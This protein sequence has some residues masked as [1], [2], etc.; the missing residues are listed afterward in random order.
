MKS[1]VFLIAG[2]VLSAACTVTANAKNFC[3]VDSEELWMSVNKD[4]SIDVTEI[5]KIT[6]HG[7]WG[8]MSREFLLQG[9]DGIKISELRVDNVLFTQKS[10][11]R[12]GEYDLNTLEPRL[13]GKG[14]LAPRLEMRWR[15][16]SPSDPPYD[17]TGVRITLKYRVTG[18][19]GQY[20]DYDLL[21]WNP[22]RVYRQDFI[23]DIKVRVLFPDAVKAPDVKFS[24]NALNAVKEVAPGQRMVSFMAQSLSPQ[25]DFRFSIK[26]PKGMIEP[27]KS[28]RNLYYYNLKPWTL[29]VIVAITA[30]F[31]FLLNLLKGRDP[32]VSAEQIA[33][34]NLNYI[35]PGMAGLV[36]DESFD[37]RDIAVTVIDLAKRGFL[38]ITQLSNEP[39]DYE[40]RLLRSPLPDTL[41]KF[42]ENM[43]IEMFGTLTRDSRTT[44]GKLQYNFYRRIARIRHAAWVDAAGWFAVSPQHARNSFLLVG[45]GIAAFGVIMAAI[46]IP[47]AIFL[48]IWCVVFGGIPIYRIIHYI[49][50]NGWR[51][52]RGHLV[53]L[54]LILLGVGVAAYSIAGAYPWT[55]W[56]FDVGVA[57]FISGLLTAAAGPAMA[58]R[59][60]EGC[61]LARRIKQLY[62]RLLEH[63]EQEASL[64]PYQQLIWMLVMANGKT[65]IPELPEEEYKDFF[66][67]L[68]PGGG[69]A[70]RQM[71]LT[72]I[73]S[74]S[75]VSNN[76]V[77]QNGGG[78]VSSCAYSQH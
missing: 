72:L 12:K 44:T 17:Y 60:T 38:K 20:Q 50:D 28:F 46:K 77:A 31:L 62:H 58:R 47:I 69:N 7:K 39:P 4:S 24:C 48:S 29:P 56:V 43:L 6:L 40:I 1:W 27:Y 23:R 53:Y 5:R 33:A 21:S 10:P 61:I 22:L 52:L 54:P 45:L 32:K 34:I 35:R 64:S 13:H 26:L 73:D 14:S 66:Q 16:N 59:N 57:V 55:G 49:K 19:I 15:A 18:A 67:P 8:M 37:H 74:V 71:S 36:I 2:L 63:P 68:E 3:L 51:G 76:A 41:L 42:E 25:D 65:V 70:F 9:C 78:Q 30:V 11:P 75:P